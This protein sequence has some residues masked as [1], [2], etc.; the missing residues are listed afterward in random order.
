M[1]L[2]AVFIE[3][4]NQPLLILVMSPLQFLLKFVL[5]TPIVVDDEPIVFGV[6]IQSILILIQLQLGHE[7]LSVVVHRWLLI[8]LILLIT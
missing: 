1:N 4:T 7:Q 2:L 3:F 8:C 5:I 6:R